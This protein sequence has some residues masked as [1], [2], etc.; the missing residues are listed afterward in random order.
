MAR[1]V[2]SDRAPDE[3]VYRALRK[4]GSG[5]MAEIFLAEELRRGR[6]PVL[7]ALKRARI[8]GDPLIAGMLADEIRFGLLCT[9]PNVVATLGSV[10]I[11]EPDLRGARVRGWARP[12]AP[13]GCAARAW[14]TLHPRAGRPH[15]LRDLQGTRAHPSPDQFERPP[16]RRRTPRCDSAQRAAR[17]RRRGQALRLRP[18]QVRWRAHA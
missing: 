11:Q 5:G 9:H 17:H 16:A 1:L 14:R 15:R 10:Q 13:A 2:P 7:V 6:A 8:Q 18:D 3:P 12:R 4:I